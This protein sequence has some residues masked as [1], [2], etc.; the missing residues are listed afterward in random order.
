MLDLTK[1]TK[2]LQQAREATTRLAR[3]PTSKS[4][5]RRQD[6]RSEKAKG[7]TT[8]SARL[9]WQHTQTG[10][11]KREPS[12][13]KLPEG[14]RSVLPAEIDNVLDGFHRAVANSKN[15]RKTMVERSDSQSRLAEQSRFV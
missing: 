6:E 4:P 2:N 10:G 13:S 14:N 15:S 12:N 3:S 1:N 5:L 8:S 7:A 9:E 11:T